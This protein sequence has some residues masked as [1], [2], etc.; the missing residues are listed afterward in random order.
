MTRTPALLT[1]GAIGLVGTLAAGVAVAAASEQA[2]A[3]AAIA[4]FGDRMTAAGFVSEGPSDSGTDGE[5]SDMDDD[6]FEGCLGQ[7]Q[8]IVDMNDDSMAGVT[9]RAESDTYSFAPPPTSTDVLSFSLNEDTMEAVIVTVDAEHTD[10]L[11]DFVALLGSDDAAQCLE[12]AFAAEMAPDPSSP[13]ASLEPPMDASVDVAATP[14]LG[15]GDASSR[16]DL[17]MSATVMGFPLDFGFSILAARTGRS[18][19]F[20]GYSTGAE[21]LSTI[22]PQAELQALVDALA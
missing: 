14:D 5:Q 18:L 3:D 10:E 11:D 13:D 16:F 19:V 7:F 4:Q 21:P 22:D 20:V 17:D 8:S 1:I 2:S 9:A 12:D 6:V 15:I